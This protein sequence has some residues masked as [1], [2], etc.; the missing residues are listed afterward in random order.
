[1]PKA[2]EKAI[3]DS[4]RMASCY[5]DC[6][7]AELR[8]KIAEKEFGAEADEVILGN[9]A[10]ELI[11]AI[12]QYLKPEKALVTAPSFREYEAGIQI[13]GGEVLYESL[14]AEADFIVTERILERITPEVKLLFLCSPNNPTG[15]VLE[16]ELLTKVAKVCEETGTFF[17]L[18]E[19]FLPFMEE[20]ESYTMKNEL[21]RFPHLMI[22]KAFTKIYGMAGIRFGYLL[23]S[24][25]E[26]L[27]NIREVM[28][29]WNVS[30]PAQA[31]AMAALEE[32][33]YILKTKKLIAKE[34][35][36]LLE[37]LKKLGVRVIGKP[38]ANFIFFQDKADLAER[39]LERGVLIRTCSNYA[40]LKEGYF[41]IGVRSPEE[42]RALIRIWN[43]L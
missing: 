14:D 11:Y 3:I 1:M 22:L 39:F 38:A 7:M 18:D 8:K 43:E 5:P 21:R 34:R 35:R 6:V 4:L 32:D 10:S 9:G 20:E 28:Q 37:E 23:S 19:C 25:V 29:P 41:R 33:E 40:G 13:S 15:Q 16:K 17:C 12:C 2:C 24:N 27:D 30:I 42:N 26:L 31:A 36:Y